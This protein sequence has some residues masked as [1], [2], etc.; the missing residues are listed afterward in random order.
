[1]PQPAQ[2]WFQKLRE[3]L[4]TGTAAAKFLKVLLPLVGIAAV[5]GITINIFIGGNDK[6]NP[7][8]PD[9]H[10][11]GSTTP[12]GGNTP[13]TTLSSALLQPCDLGTCTAGLG[14]AQTQ[15]SS[16]PGPSCSSFPQKSEGHA[17]TA[18][19]NASTSVDVI[20]NVWQ[21]TNPQQAVAAFS[22]TAQGCSYNQNDPV[23]GAPEVVIFQSDDS[24]GNFGDDSQA[25]SIGIQGTTFPNAP[26]T[27]SGYEAVI[28]R[29]NLFASVYTSTGSA[30]SMSS[31]TL[32][33]LLNAAVR[34][35]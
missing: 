2:G 6:P 20:E 19:S 4:E 27:I 14:W 1:M 35:L 33:S 5:S 24:A 29:G 11:S 28:A 12:S 10:A 7:V 3:W 15:G 21:L 30:G 17:S 9:G 16:P 18:I 23:S 25:F 8:L 32:S 31:S 34:R 22:A 13:V 26:I